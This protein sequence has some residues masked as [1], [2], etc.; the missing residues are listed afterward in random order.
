MKARVHHFHSPDADLDTYRPDD[1]AHVG[2]LVQIMAGPADGPGA[3]SFDVVVCTP[4]WIGERA[5]T[6]G[7]TIGRHH[8]IVDRFDADQVRSYLVAAV[9]AE[10][11]ASWEA[12]A[13]RIGRIG[14]WEFE[15]YAERT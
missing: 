4:S 11:A 13:E 7:P 2:I 12:L 10:E 9:E 14:K 8:L 6:A 5:R 3:E 1:P 15:D